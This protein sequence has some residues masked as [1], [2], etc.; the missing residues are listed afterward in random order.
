MLILIKHYE[1][2]MWSSRLISH[3]IQ[4]VEDTYGN[5]K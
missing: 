4:T 5:I 3:R 2:L 1:H